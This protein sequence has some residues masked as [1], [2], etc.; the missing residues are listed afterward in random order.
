MLF[1]KVLWR[2]KRHAEKV[3]SGLATL[4]GI[5]VFGAGTYCLTNTTIDIEWR[6]VGFVSML[7]GVLLAYTGYK[8]FGR[9]F[10]F[11]LSGDEL[12]GNYDH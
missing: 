2:A 5:F 11:T 3:L 10:D 6:F 7:A 9:G 4:I 12:D 8:S 1:K